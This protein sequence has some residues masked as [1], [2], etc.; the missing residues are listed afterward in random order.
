MVLKVIWVKRE[1]DIFAKGAGHKFADLP[2]GQNQS[3]I[4]RLSS[5]ARRKM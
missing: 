3:I 1:A 5:P 4:C 2:V